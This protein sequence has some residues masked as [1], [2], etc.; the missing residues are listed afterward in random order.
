MNEKN[1]KKRLD[2]QTKIIS[3]QSEEIEA[4]KLQ[5]EKLKLELVKKDEV[6]NSVAPLKEELIQH[7]AEV[8]KYKIKY[9]KLIDEIRKMKEILNQTVYKGRWWIIKFLIK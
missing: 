3:R 7:I 2:V 1:F 4:L 8:K 9:L 6:I 5:N